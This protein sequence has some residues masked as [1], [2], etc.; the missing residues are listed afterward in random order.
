[1]IPEEIKTALQNW[2]LEQGLSEEITHTK[3]IGGGSINSAIKVSTNDG[4]WF[5]KFN[6]AQA[7]PQMFESEYHGLKLMAE[8]QTIRIPQPL[9]FYEGNHYS[10]ILMEW[11]EQGARQLNF[12]PDFAKQLSQM[13]QCTEDYFGLEFDN[14]MGSLPQKNSK[15]ADFV[16]FFIQERLEPQIKL[17]RDDGYINEKHIRQSERLYNELPSIFPEEKPSLV[18]GDLW[19]GNFMNDEKGNPVIMDP[20]VY[21]G[22]REVDIAMTTMFGGFSSKF[23][24]QYQNNYPMETGWESRLDFYKLYPILI[25]VNLFGYS[26]VGSFEN[27]VSRF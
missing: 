13:H 26:Y 21:F 11:I 12:W 9:N 25:H 5:L 7:H 22:H 6:F 1:M 20:A 16:S 19:S 2:F 15:H 17:A 24:E 23:Y 8:A 18:H 3:S 4:A 10:C 14:Y 27:I